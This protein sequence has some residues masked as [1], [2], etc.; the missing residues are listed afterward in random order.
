MAND[1]NAFAKFNG[2][3]TARRVAHRRWVALKSA[4]GSEASEIRAA[5]LLFVRT[6]EEYHAELQRLITGGA[7][8]AAICGDTHEDE[9]E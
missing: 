3:T 8:P 4:P 6:D 9:E 2:L 7:T 5:W 1:P